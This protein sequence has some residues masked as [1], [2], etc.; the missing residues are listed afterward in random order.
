MNVPETE[1]ARLKSEIERL[2]CTIGRLHNQLRFA[3][4]D[5]IF[6]NTLT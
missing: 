3:R 1:I 5:A 6:K 4:R 2:K